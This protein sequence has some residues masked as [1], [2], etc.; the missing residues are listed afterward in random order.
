[1]PSLMRRQ[2][3]FQMSLVRSLLTALG[4]ICFLT[5]CSGLLNAGD[6]PQWRG[7]NRDGK[8]TGFKAPEVWPQQLTQKWK[9]AVGVGDS[10]PALVGDR[11]YTFG[12]REN[13]EL[14][15][16]LEAGTGKTIWANRYPAGRVVTGPPARHPGTRSSPA[17]VGGRVFSLGVG[18]ILSCLDAS[19]GK[20]FWRKQSTDDY[21]GI[22][23]N[24]DTSMSPI[25]LD[26][27][28]VVHV[29]G[30]TN[31][32][33]FAFDVA[34]GAPKWKWDGDGPASSSPIVM[35]TSHGTRQLVT[36]TAK[37]VV[38][39][40]MPDGRLL[41]R[42]P[43][44]AVQGNNTTPVI[45]G[46]TVIYT[47]QGKGMF[48]VR[49]EPQGDTFAAAPIWTNSQQGA[50]FTT[51]VLKEGLLFGYHNR[52]FCADA[53]TGATL[54]TDTTGRGNSAALVDAGPVILA[55]TVN[56]EL[57][58]FKP[59]DKE[60]TELLRTKVADTEIWAHPVVAGSRVY[61][62]DRE[63]VALWTIE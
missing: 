18:G 40:A 45:D 12:R 50:R 20:V 35:T 49:I 57:V 23:Y 9:V 27:L 48:A 44:E 15:Q 26:G 4:A 60:Y 30:K 10:T 3:Q 46:Q 16:C 21:Q 29:G 32:A 51:P 47:G 5:A 37:Y 11:L 39:L 62:R 31:G 25:I 42:I 43:F 36:L 6:W 58:A 41:W 52:F 33:I 14:I 22:P 56:S 24:A 61:V 17:V 1:M 63:S 19:T 54:W 53:K 55:T 2:T 34:S 13:D 28:C 7:P 8:V 38:G 59:S